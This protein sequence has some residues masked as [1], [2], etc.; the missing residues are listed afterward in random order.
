LPVRN[1]EGKKKARS[2]DEHGGEGERE[3]GNRKINIGAH[4]EIKKTDE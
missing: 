1:D 2:K 4:Y 3:G